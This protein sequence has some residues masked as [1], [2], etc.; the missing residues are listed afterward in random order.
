[1][2]SLTMTNLTNS[3]QNTD[4]CTEFDSNDVEQDAI[5]FGDKPNSYTYIATKF[6]RSN[7]T[8]IFDFRTF[9][10]NGVLFIS[11]NIIIKENISYFILY[12]I[13]FLANKAINS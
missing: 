2:K 4:R 1:M 12:T 6:W 9:Y 8:L 5:K 10:P 3:M 11:V 13:I 7:F